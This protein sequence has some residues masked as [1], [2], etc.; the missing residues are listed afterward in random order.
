MAV[1]TI[2]RFWLD[3]K[4]CWHCRFGSTFRRGR[5]ASAAFPLSCASF[6]VCKTVVLALLLFLLPWMR[7]LVRWGGEGICFS[8]DR[9]VWGGREDFCLHTHTHQHKKNWWTQQWP[10]KHVRR[11]LFTVA[12]FFLPAMH[13]LVFFIPGLTHAHVSVQARCNAIAFFVRRIV[14]FYNCDLY[15][16]MS[17][18]WMAVFAD[19]F[20]F[21]K[22]N[23][24]VVMEE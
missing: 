13:Y 24:T 8:I 10:P 18:L 5:G 17:L 3:T 6:V 15:I 9:C 1:F 12:V 19:M 23:N 21:E 4:S 2:A 22:W 14:S 20:F 11:R 16:S 7:Q